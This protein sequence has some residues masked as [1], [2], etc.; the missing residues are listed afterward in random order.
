MASPIK[1][2]GDFDQRLKSAMDTLGKFDKFF[3]LE[4]ARGTSWSKTQVDILWLIR[5]CMDHTMSALS[6]LAA[7]ARDD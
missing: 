6:D 2:R 4:L 3:N 5:D 7:A 1:L